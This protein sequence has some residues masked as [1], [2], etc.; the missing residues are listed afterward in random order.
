MESRSLDRLR[1]ACLFILA[2][3]APAAS[4]TPVAAVRDFSARQ[5]DG[6]TFT[7]A[8]HGGEVVLLAFFATWSK[9]SVVELRHLEHLFERRRTD[10]LL[11]VALAV[12]GPETIAQVPA[13]ASRNGLTFPVVLDEDSHIVSLYN[14][15][16]DVPLTV[17]HRR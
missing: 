1:L 13:F 14:P 16:R 2:A 5:I 12:D 6:R 8:E 7:L 9:P 4:P 10:G 3:C 15:K 17:P 11:V